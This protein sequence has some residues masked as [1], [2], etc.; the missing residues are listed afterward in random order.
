MSSIKTLYSKLSD[1]KVRVAI[2]EI[3]HA[4]TTGVFGDDSIIRNLCRETAK[5]TNMDVSSNLLMVQIGVLKEAAYRW[6]ETLEIENFDNKTQ[7]SQSILDFIEKFQPWENV[8]GEEAIRISH[9]MAEMEPIDTSNSLHLYQET[10]VIKDDTYT[11]T[12][13]IGGTTEEAV[14]EKKPKKVLK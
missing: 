14:I 12:W 2:E 5:I 11:F 8:I 4:E 10:Y 3:K 1:D 6:V 13:A 9:L 7:P